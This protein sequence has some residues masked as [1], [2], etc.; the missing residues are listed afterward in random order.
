[1]F[2]DIGLLICGLVVGIVLSIISYALSLAT[3]KPDFEI[4]DY[5]EYGI[6]SGSFDVKRYN[7]DKHDADIANGVCEQTN[8]GA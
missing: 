8:D 1:M 6:N 4:E 2:E 5:E 7:K 3:K